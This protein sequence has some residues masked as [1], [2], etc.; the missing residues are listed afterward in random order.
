MN[1]SSTLPIVAND[2]YLTLN[3]R[4]TLIALPFLFTLALV[5]NSL[6]LIILCRRMLLQHSCTHYFI[7]QSSSNILYTIVVLIVDWINTVFPMNLATRSLPECRIYAYLSSVTAVSSVYM[8]VL[9]SI[10]RWCASATSEFIRRWIKVKIARRAI[11]TLYIIVASYRMEVLFTYNVVQGQCI[12][13]ASIVDQ[14]VFIITFYVIPHIFNLLFG[15]M[16]IKNVHITRIRPMAITSVTRQRTTTSQQLQQQQNSRRRT[17]G[18]LIRM[19][20]AQVLISIIFFGPYAIFRLLIF[21]KLIQLTGILS[22]GYRLSVSWMSLAYGTSLFAYILS[23][24]IYR[25]ELI[26]VLKKSLEYLK[27][28]TP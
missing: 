20:L 24:T 3:I 21:F 13:T 5:T 28:V 16:T 23:G 22:F 9:A 15:F 12:W 26:Q 27:R 11:C 10:D 14:I 25:T 4:Y 17:E 7:A 2:A 18:Q 8:L 1:N 6:N 19:L